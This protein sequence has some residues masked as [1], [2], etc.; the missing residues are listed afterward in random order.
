MVEYLCGAL[1]DFTC[2]IHV[3]FTTPSKALRIAI[4]IVST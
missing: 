2:V 1:S 4:L 3:P